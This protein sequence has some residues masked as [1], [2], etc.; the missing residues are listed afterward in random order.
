MQLKQVN[1]VRRS[2]AALVREGAA[3]ASPENPIDAIVI[4][5]GPSGK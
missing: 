3:G 4:G 5:V 1:G 2:T